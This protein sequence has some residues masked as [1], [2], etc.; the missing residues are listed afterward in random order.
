MLYDEKCPICGKLNKG[1]YLDETQ[2]L[3]VCE[4]CGNEIQIPRFKK[5]KQSPPVYDRR[6]LVITTNN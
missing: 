1:M 5:K 3:F 4:K 6:R 2:G